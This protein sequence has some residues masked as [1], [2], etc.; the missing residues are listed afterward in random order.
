MESVAAITGWNSWLSMM[1]KLTALLVVL[2]VALVVGGEYPRPW[3][4]EQDDAP[5][6]AARPWLG[7]AVT[8]AAAHGG[9]D[10]GGD[11]GGVS[12]EVLQLM[13]ETPLVD[14]HN[15]LPWELR[16]QEEARVFHRAFNLS[17]PVDTLHT[18]IPRLRAGKVG[19]QFWSVYVDCTQQNKDAVRATLEQID[20]VHKLALRYPQTFAIATTAEEAMDAFED[21]KIAS[22]MGME[23]GHHIDSSLGALRMFYRLGAR[24]MSL[25]HNCNTPWADSC[26][27]EPAH[28]GLTA[29]GREVVL[30]MNRLGMLVDL[31]HTSED[32]MLDVLD[33][34]R[35]PV[36]F[37]HSNAFALCPD[38]RNVPDSVLSQLEENGGVVMVN[39]YPPFVSCEEEASISQVAD[40]IDY[41]RSIC[42]SGCVGI[43]ADYDGVSNLVTGLE[44]V[45][46]YPKLFQELY[47]RGYSYEEL[48]KVMGLNILRA[49]SQAETV[50]AAL[51]REVFP[52]E[53]TIY[54]PNQCRSDY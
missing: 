16:M 45:A 19:G 46:S 33:V 27:E 22:F 47:Q 35:A 18:D 29:F 36:I 9:E 10:E 28:N 21:G 43:G 42:G 50:A 32:T 15:D 3:A 14:G 12:A 34:A 20:V 53:S 4:C 30:E 11:I 26:A 24:Y 40:H 17:L 2:G 38:P 39:F 8:S 49:L 44:S 13:E 52:Q 1:R 5:P 48:A 7:D 31:S 37:S 51:Q 6:Y 23:G 54:P 25:T 41:I